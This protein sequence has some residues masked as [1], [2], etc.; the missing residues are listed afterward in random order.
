MGGCKAGKLRERVGSCRGAACG[1]GNGRRWQAAAPTVPWQ[2]GTTLAVPPAH[3]QLVE[4][5]VHLQDGHLLAVVSVG[6]VEHLDACTEGVVQADG[7]HQRC[8]HTAVGVATPGAAAGAG[9][10]LVAACRRCCCVLCRR[11]RPA[12]GTHRGRSRSACGRRGSRTGWSPGRTGRRGRTA[13]CRPVGGSGGGG[14]D[15]TQL[16][17][18]VWQQ[19]LVCA[20]TSRSSEG[21]HTHAPQHSTVTTYTSPRGN[22]AGRRRR[23]KDRH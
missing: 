4:L 14:D 15:E 1:G 8:A 20:P 18:R 9:A 11:P 16:S 12:S 2:A 3:L 22:G 13:S 5:A 6:A 10:M 21:S 19:G 17:A 7:G 23:S